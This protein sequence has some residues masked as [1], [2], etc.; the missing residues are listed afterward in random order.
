MAAIRGFE[1]RWHSVGRYLKSQSHIQERCSDWEVPLITEGISL[2]AAN[3]IFL[4][5]ERRRYFS[6][7]ECA[8]AIHIFN[9]SPRSIPITEINSRFSC[10]GVEDT[11]ATLMLI[12]LP[13]PEQ[14][15]CPLT[16]LFRASLLNAS[17][18]Q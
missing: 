18:E 11:C 7:Q 6:N 3:R 15:L 9:P 1:L 17:S 4:D 10:I 2:Y 8:V 12:F 16:T 13:A 14:T 5:L